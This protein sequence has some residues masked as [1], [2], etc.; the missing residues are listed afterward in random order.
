[1]VGEKT[2]KVY[3]ESLQCTYDHLS[4]SI[5]KITTVLKLDSGLAVLSAHNF[6]TIFSQ[7]EQKNYFCEEECILYAGDLRMKDG[8]LQVLSG[9][10]FREVILW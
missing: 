7:Q 9:T 6:V 4:K 1:M 8:C 2:L 5:D 10:V 3:D